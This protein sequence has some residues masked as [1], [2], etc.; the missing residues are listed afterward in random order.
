V[1]FDYSPKRIPLKDITTFEQRIHTVSEKT[2]MQCAS[3]RP[4]PETIQADK[5]RIL[6]AVVLQGEFV[7]FRKFLL[8]LLAFPCLIGVEQIQISSIPENREY[9]LSLWVHFT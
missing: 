9:N 3:V 4:R 8:Q 2:G 5:D 7:D 1:G 6:V